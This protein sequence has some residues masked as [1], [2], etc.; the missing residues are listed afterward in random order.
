VFSWARPG[1]IM[2]DFLLLAGRPP[3]AG[4]GVLFGI[5]AMAAVGQPVGAPAGQACT[6]RSRSVIRMS[7]VL[8]GAVV[9]QEAEAGAVHLVGGVDSRAPEA[10]AAF[11][12]G[13]KGLAEELALSEAEGW[14]DDWPRGRP[15]S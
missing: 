5:A 4:M 9:Q 1:F 7:V 12:G 8:V 3:G 15:S 6:E 14:G 11:L 2:G 13:D 10:Q